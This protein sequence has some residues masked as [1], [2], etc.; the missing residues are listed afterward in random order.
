MG[1]SIL[2]ILIRFLIFMLLTCCANSAEPK[3][4]SWQL[5]VQNRLQW[6]TNNGY[7]GGF[8]FL[9]NIL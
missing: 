6:E 2:S 4:F 8:K 7:C 9:N 5:P 3:K 1:Y